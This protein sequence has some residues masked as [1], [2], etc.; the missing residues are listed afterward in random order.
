[1]RDAKSPGTALCELQAH[2]RWSDGALDVRSARPVYLV[3][4]EDGVAELAA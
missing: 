1:V 3:K 4:L 2:S